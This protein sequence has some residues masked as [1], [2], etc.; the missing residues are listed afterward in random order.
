[1]RI[2]DKT[3]CKSC[4]SKNFTLMQGN[5]IPSGYGCSSC[6]YDTDATEPICFSCEVGFFKRNSNCEKYPQGCLYCSSES[7]CLACHSKFTLINDLCINYNID[8]CDSCRLG[9][10]GS[11]LDCLTCSEKSYLNEGSC[12]KCPLFCSECSYNN[13]F[14]FTKCIVGFGLTPDGQCLP[15][16]SNCESCFI[17]KLCVK[18]VFLKNVYLKMMDLVKNALKNYL[19]IVK[20]VNL[21]KTKNSMFVTLVLK[22]LF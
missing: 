18:H 17:K 5:C 14:E 4:K 6:S 10:D 13:R 8:K 22:V 9:S 2:A 12:V 7:K 1:M 21:M 20:P 19:V 11:S 16:S 15:C 3:M